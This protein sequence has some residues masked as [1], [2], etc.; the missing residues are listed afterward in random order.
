MYY[1]LE[2]PGRVQLLVNSAD[3]RHVQVLHEGVLPAG[4]HRYE[5]ST[6]HLAPGV[7]YVTLLL[8]GEPLV[9]RAVKL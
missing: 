3:G 6:G 2:R 7:H 1:T 9:K 4:E 5:W 8:D